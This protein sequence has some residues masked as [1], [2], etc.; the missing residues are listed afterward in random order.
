M[1]AQQTVATAL[2]RRE[3]AIAAGVMVLL[4]LLRSVVFV[5]WEQAHFDSDQAITG[6]MARHLSQHRAFPVFYYGQNYMLAV[7]AWLAAPLFAVAGASVATL[8]LPLLATNIAIALLL[9]RTI[10]RQTGLRPFL[11]V[12]P[13]LFFVLPPP[14]TAARLVEAN[15]GNVEPTL[16][17]ILL[18]LTRARP[19]WGGLILGVGFLQ[20]EFTIYGFI[21]LLIVEAFDGSLFTKDGVRRRLVMLRTAAEV[22]LVVQ[23]VK[24]FSSAAGPGTSLANV[25]HPRDNL[26][27]LASR[28]C[29]DPATAL[30]G[31]AK[32]AT[33]H[34]PVLFGTRVTPLA[35]FGIDSRVRE[36]MPGSWVFLLAAI[37]LAVIVVSARLIRDRQWRPEYTFCS[38]LV[39]V[40][41]LS[42]AGYVA[43]RCGELGFGT[44]R[45]D[46]LSLI[47]AVGLG[48]WFLSTRPSK[49]LTR[50]WVVC[51]AAWLSVSALAHARL[52]AEYLGGPPI[53]AKQ[54]VVRN[55][56]AQGVQYAVSDYWIAYAVTF[57]TD[58]QVIVASEDFVRIPAYQDIVAEHADKAVRISRSACVGGR[59]VTPGL[60]LCPR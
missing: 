40:A 35:D 51:L 27:E 24:Q 22:W 54:L 7:E 21:A 52:L 25:F 50:V 53:G 20:R 45:Y 60:Y 9:L 4:V 38:Y 16:Y 47:G 37:L 11:A 48:A 14:G 32:L 23:W 5:F 18:W 41:S 19:G 10:E 33:E 13:T 30:R 2:R 59:T 43:G 46:L 36:G 58:E 6:L 26:S 42:A 12:L 57:M 44:V 49:I 55:L 3:R 8:K 31:M 1:L 28:V 29:I 17:I 56:R 39:L 34:W 15:G